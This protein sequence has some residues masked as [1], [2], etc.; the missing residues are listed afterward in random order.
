MGGNNV[1]IICFYGIL[2]KS[3]LRM[4][5]V[6]TNCNTSSFLFGCCGRVS[7]LPQWDKLIKF[8]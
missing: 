2:K 7:C 1:N 3:Q 8:D 6:I 4:E 5:A